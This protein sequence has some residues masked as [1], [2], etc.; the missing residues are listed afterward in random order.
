MRAFPIRIGIL[1]EKDR[2]FFSNGGRAL[3]E[4]LALPMTKGCDCFLGFS[5]QPHDGTWN[6]LR[7][8]RKTVGFLLLLSLSRRFRTRPLKGLTLY[9]FFSKQL[10][11]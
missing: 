8:F 9:L 3:Y 1:T 6:G 10:V 4:T 5:F 11:A 7:L 2:W